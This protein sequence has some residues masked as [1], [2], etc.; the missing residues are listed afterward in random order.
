MF[1]QSQRPAP[2]PPPRTSCAFEGWVKIAT[3][4]LVGVVVA[5][6]YCLPAAYAL[7]MRG[8]SYFDKDGD[9]DI[10]AAIPATV[11]M[12]SASGGKMFGIALYSIGT[13]ALLAFFHLK[14]IYRKFCEVVVSFKNEARG[15]ALCCLLSYLGLSVLAL[16]TGGLGASNNVDGL[17]IFSYTIKRA[18]PA[19]VVAASS[20]LMIM[21][22]ALGNGSWILKTSKQ[23][24]DY[25]RERRKVKDGFKLNCD[26]KLAILLAIMLPAIVLSYFSFFTIYSKDGCTVF[27]PNL[28]ND[29]IANG[30]VLGS[31]EDSTAS[32]YNNKT[33]FMAY[34]KKINVG[35][36]VTNPALDAVCGTNGAY[37]MLRYLVMVA[38]KIA[39][40]LGVL[41]CGEGGLGYRSAA[42]FT[43]VVAVG[44]FIMVPGLGQFAEVK[45]G[46]SFLYLLS[47]SA[48]L[49]AGLTN[50]T[51][52]LMDPWV[53][54]LESGYQ[55]LFN[56][57]CKRTSELGR[58]SDFLSH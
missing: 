1:L 45:D 51:V 4:T 35:N 20:L 12:L 37:Y 24:S 36:N 44:A 11:D 2:P 27:F 28:W 31:S 58:S 33:E 49:L 46:L 29:I 21:I 47:L 54:R 30:F 9:D 10:L 15:K 22:T 40:P 6:P 7:V 8:C 14:N 26:K 13:N 50:N 57:C 39:F 43:L 38:N 42:L 17:I 52:K 3:L 34:Y 19:F 5:I 48:F 55:W 16:P 41:Q 53:D 25:I 23:A 32:F 56:K 18:L